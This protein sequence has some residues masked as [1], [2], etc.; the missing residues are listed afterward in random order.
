MSLVL[1]L[2]AIIANVD[3][4]RLVYSSTP[5][6]PSAT[7]RDL[8]NLA[9]S[10]EEPA[11]VKTNVTIPSYQVAVVFFFETCQWKVSCWGTGAIIGYFCASTTP[12]ALLL[13]Q[14]MAKAALATAGL[15]KWCYTRV[16]D[17]QS[18][19][20]GLT[21]DRA[22]ER[23]G[24]CIRAGFSERGPMALVP[25]SPLVFSTRRGASV[26]PSHA[27]TAHSAHSRSSTPDRTLASHRQRSGSKQ[28]TTITPVL[29]CVRVRVSSGRAGAGSMADV[30]DVQRQAVLCTRDMLIT[31]SA[32]IGTPESAAAG[33]WQR[34]AGFIV[35]R[36]SD[37]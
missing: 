6:A 35:N 14:V 33:S 11:R 16:L 26:T 15:G 36:R 5:I 1:S 23:Q 31:R 13:C 3:T 4:A 24:V 22:S 19:S 27:Q 21:V 30:S 37:D 17:T 20:S 12:R 18:R 28:S 10:Q 8:H 29:P 2:S 32:N 7:P 25:F 9:P 34:A